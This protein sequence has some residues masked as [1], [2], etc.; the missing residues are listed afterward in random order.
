MSLE[1][2]WFLIM[3]ISSRLSLLLSGNFILQGWWT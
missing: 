1:F 2:A 3:D